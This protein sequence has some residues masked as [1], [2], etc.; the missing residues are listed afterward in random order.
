M[1]SHQADSIACN[2]RKTWSYQQLQKWLVLRALRIGTLIYSQFIYIFFWCSIWTNPSTLTLKPFLHSV[3][4]LFF[5]SGKLMCLFCDHRLVVDAGVPHSQKKVLYKITKE[6]TNVKIRQTTNAK[7]RAKPFL[8]H[9]LCLRFN[10]YSLF[11]VWFFVSYSTYII[12]HLNLTHPLLIKP[13]KSKRKK[14]QKK[15]CML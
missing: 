2:I 7:R 15:I 5:C 3:W 9:L 8:I 6:K 12:I 1:I 10:H 14:K 4:S 13:Q 11:D